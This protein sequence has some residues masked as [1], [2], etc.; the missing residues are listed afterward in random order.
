[1]GHSLRFS[2]SQMYLAFRSGIR[3]NCIRMKTAFP[4]EAELNA[5]W[6]EAKLELI[7]DTVYRAV[8][9]APRVGRHRPREF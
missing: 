1:M 7:H 2:E 8:E 9:Y 4:S 5:M 6:A 3:R